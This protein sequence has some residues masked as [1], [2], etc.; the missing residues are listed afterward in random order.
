MSE[1]VVEK[2]ESAEAQVK[3]TEVVLVAIPS[4]KLDNLLFKDAVHVDKDIYMLQVT[5]DQKDTLLFITPRRYKSQPI[6][7]SVN[8]KKSWL[9]ILA[10]KILKNDL[11]VVI[12][13]MNIVAS[14]HRDKLINNARI[15]EIA[16]NKAMDE[17]VVLSVGEATRVK[18]MIELLYNF[19]TTEN[20]LSQDRTVTRV[21]AS[22]MEVLKIVRSITG[23]TKFY[24][25]GSNNYD[26]NIEPKYLNGYRLRAECARLGACTISTNILKD[27]IKVALFNVGITS[28]PVFDLSKDMIEREKITRVVK[29]TDFISSAPSDLDV[30]NMYLA[31]QYQ[32]G[33][34][35]MPNGTIRYMRG[36]KI[37]A[38]V[39]NYA[40]LGR[41]LAAIHSPYNEEF[42]YQAMT[43]HYK[44]LIV[45]LLPERRK[46]NYKRSISHITDKL[47]KAYDKIGRAEKT[48]QFLN[49]QM[50]AL[51]STTLE[52]MITSIQQKVRTVIVKDVVE[53]KNGFAIVIDTFPFVRK[54]TLS[55]TVTVKAF[56]PSY[57][58]AVRVPHIIMNAEMMSS[59]TDKILQVKVNDTFA[60]VRDY[61]SANGLGSYRPFPHVSNVIIPTS[62]NN[63]LPT[64]LDHVVK[65]RLVG[66]NVCLGGFGV[67]FMRSL[68]S[69]NITS[70]IDTVANW[71]YNG[72]NPDDMW[73][74]TIG[75]FPTSNQI[76]LKKI[77][78]EGSEKC[79]ND[80]CS[81]SKIVILPKLLDITVDSKMESPK[82]IILNVR[83]NL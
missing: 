56:L 43:M 10:K 9:R 69:Y 33:T 14:L 48:V 73:G 71:I 60:G 59:I 2:I 34:I 40:V 67:Q 68:M 62:I 3:I 78:E 79:L 75:M 12:D 46:E 81:D 1:Q 58:I 63:E 15:R 66:H 36:E 77:N 70:M 30:E 38:Q 82:K 44:K 28:I 4:Y 39:Y 64:I 54:I 5:K 23:S 57:R 6:Y 18:Y 27:E 65:G 25:I 32:N 76:F 51:E 19:S 35:C 26:C 61:L 50:G 24:S 55:S 29:L 52:E 74:Q 45:K 13:G 17:G 80:I 42:V 7:S 47:N 37:T 8:L 41:V 20:V 11:P 83:D 16:L 21:D 31:V 53:L 49:Q 72:I 22:V